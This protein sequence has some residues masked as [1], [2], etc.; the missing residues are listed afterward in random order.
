MPST[1]LRESLKTRSNGYSP[2]RVDLTSIASI[3]FNERK[4]RGGWRLEHFVVDLLLG[5]Q[6]G[7]QAKDEED[8]ELRTV[9]SRSAPIAA[10]IGITIDAPKD[11]DI[12]LR[13]S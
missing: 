8:P 4:N 7:F 13:D 9:F 3:P 11:A 2:T 10:A 5:C 12:L 1:E 6:A